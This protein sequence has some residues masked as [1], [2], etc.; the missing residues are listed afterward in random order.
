[1]IG[2]LHEAREFFVG[3]GLSSLDSVSATETQY[4]SLAGMTDKMLLS[5]MGDANQ[6]WL[7]LFEILA[8]I[9]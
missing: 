5:S 3:M 6:K 9:K 1:M 4:S 7:A 2:I 8:D